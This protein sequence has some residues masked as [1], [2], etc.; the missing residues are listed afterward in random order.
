MNSYLIKPS[1]KLHNIKLFKSNLKKMIYY[2]KAN[3]KY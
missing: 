2:Y 3:L 1:N